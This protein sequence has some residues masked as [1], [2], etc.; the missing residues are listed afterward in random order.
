MRANVGDGS[1]I[2]RADGREFFMFQ[3]LIGTAPI[4][5]RP[6]GHVPPKPFP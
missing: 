2:I 6:A 1:G 3:G 4:G 5:P